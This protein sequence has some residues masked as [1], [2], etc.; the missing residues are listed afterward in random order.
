MMAG[1][2]FDDAA[3][4]VAAVESYLRASGTVAQ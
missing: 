2:T 4:F 3:R 1:E